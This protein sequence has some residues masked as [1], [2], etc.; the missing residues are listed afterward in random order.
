VPIEFINECLE[1]GVTD[2]KVVIEL[3]KNPKP[4]PPE[5][6]EPEAKEPAAA[7]PA[8]PEAPEPPAQTK[9][10]AQGS[11][12]EAAEAQEPATPEEIE[13]SRKLEEI[14]ETLV[15]YGMPDPVV[16]AFLAKARD[17]GK[18]SLVLTRIARAEDIIGDCTNDDGRKRKYLKAFF[19]NLPAHGVILQDS[20]ED[21]D[22][23]L[24]N[25]SEQ[26]ERQEKVADKG[27]TE[28]KAEAKP[29]VKLKHIGVTNGN[30]AFLEKIREVE[31]SK[32]LKV[33]FE[34]RKLDPHEFAYVV[35]KTFRWLTNKSAQDVKQEDYE[36][37]V[38]RFSNRAQREV[39]GVLRMLVKPAVG[40]GRMSLKTEGELGPLPREILC[41][42][43]KAHFQIH[44][45][46]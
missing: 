10:E 45:G 37:N 9:P 13:A 40:S 20:A 22:K 6:P 27:P 43:K 38:R 11:Q 3:H 4:K 12:D 34:S 24:L 7:E 14:R 41:F 46:A 26:L 29:K 16:S 39:E 23:G 44:S 42:I 17:S 31:V 5:K 33:F 1:S 25:Y 15:S 18:E 32:D 8:K 28:P 21:F 19:M 36:S 2:F 30:T 35:L